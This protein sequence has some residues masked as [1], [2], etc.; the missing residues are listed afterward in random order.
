MTVVAWADAALAFDT[1]GVSPLDWAKWKNEGPGSSE[2]LNS[3]RPI[4]SP[5]FCT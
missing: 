5:P 4:Y 3:G 2:A 1:G